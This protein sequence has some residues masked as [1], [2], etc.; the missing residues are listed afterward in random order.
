MSILWVLQSPELSG[1][2][3]GSGSLA[4]GSGLT[5]GSVRLIRLVLYWIIYISEPSYHCSF[6]LALQ[7]LMQ[8]T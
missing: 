7:L 8:F 4:G 6:L 3:S 5:G 2:A 1:S